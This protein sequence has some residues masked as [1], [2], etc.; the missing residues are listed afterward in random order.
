MP[1]VALLLSDT[2]LPAR[3]PGARLLVD[4]QAVSGVTQAQVLANN[5][6]A[7]N[8]FHVALAIGADP[9]F[10][11]PFWAST[12]SIAAELQ[13]NLDGSGFVSLIQGKVDD[14]TLDPINGVLQIE[15]RD[16]TAALIEARTQETFS[17]R[18]ASEIAILLAQ[19]HGLLPVV[20]PTS[21]PVG[22]YYQNE[23]DRITLNA[24]S[25]ATTEWD[26]LVFL[27]RQEGFDVFV[28]GSSLYFQPPAPASAP[29]FLLRPDLLVTLRLRRSLTLAR[30]IEV[31]VKSWNARQK[32]SFTQTARASGMPSGGS[33]GGLPAPPQAYVYVRPNLTP[34]QAL[35]FAQQRL[36]ELTQHE[37]VIELQMPGELTLTPRTPLL[38]DGTATDFD[39]LYLIDAIER[40][41]HWT[42]GFTQRIRAKNTSPRVQT[43]TPADIVGAVTG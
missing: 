26:L 15:G 38:L 20:T 23:H 3:A 10:P 14:V 17:N 8:T 19:R 4:G 42:G 30:D 43:T 31:T 27:A 39:Q 24:F 1:E 34:D 7:A 33:Q 25:H 11:A 29:P 13:F 9:A 12:R 28:E 16:L 32:H 41:F 2:L 35:K 21:T 6:Y 18:T 36:R 22:R 5:H 40:D 37:R